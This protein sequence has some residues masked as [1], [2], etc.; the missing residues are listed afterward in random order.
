MS[1]AG[2][3]EDGRIRSHVLRH[4]HWE[5]SCTASILEDEFDG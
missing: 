4:G 3:T 2:M 5:D 1:A